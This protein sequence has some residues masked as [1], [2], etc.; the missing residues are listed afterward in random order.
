MQQR[1]AALAILVAIAWLVPGVARPADHAVLGSALVVKDPSTPEKR[2]AATKAKDTVPTGA[3][4][5]NPIADGA[6]L[7]VDL[8]GARPS[9]QTFGLPAGTSPLRGKPFWSGDATKGFKYGDP[10]GEN[11]PVKSAQIKSTKGLLQLKASI[12]GK[13]G[14]VSL[15][16]PNP[17]T[18]GCVL[19]T[20]N[21]GD[22]YSVRFA[23]G[24]RTNTA[25]AFKMVKPSQ[26]GSC[27]TDIS[28]TTSTVV[29][30][31]TDVAAS[32]TSTSAAVA[33]SSTS[34]TSTST[35]PPTT[36][37]GT[38]ST[39]STSLPAGPA[40]LELTLASH[41]V[42]PGATVAV[43]S[44]VRDAAGSLIAPPPAVTLSVEAL[45]TVNGPTPT[46]MD[47]LVVVDLDTTGNFLVRGQV[48]G[49]SIDATTTVSVLA[50]S[51]QNQQIASVSQ[52][53]VSIGVALAA[54]ADAIRRGDEASASSAKAD[55]QIAA[56]GIDHDLLAA[57]AVYAPAA[58][59]P[60][61]T[62]DLAAAG[63]SET[64][65]DL[66][67][68]STVSSLLTEYDGLVAFLAGLDGTNVSD[69]QIAALRNHVTTIHALS[70]TLAAATPTVVG[71]TEA[72]DDLTVLLMHRV[73]R[74][75]Q[76]VAQLAATS[77]G[78]V[79]VAATPA[80]SWIVEVGEALGLIARPARAQFLFDILG[81]LGAEGELVSATE[82]MYGD[83]IADIENAI[84]IVT[85]A[86]LIRP[87][88]GSGLCAAVGS[89]FL[90]GVVPDNPGSYLEGSGFDARLENNQTLFIG[91]EALSP[92]RNFVTAA[93]LDPEHIHNLFDVFLFFKD[94]IELLRAP[95]EA[96]EV[97][98]HATRQPSSI[99]PGAGFI[100]EIGGDH[101]VFDE[102]FPDVLGS[103]FICIAPII[104]I[105]HDV[106]HG[107]VSMLTVNMIRP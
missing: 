68:R 72:A 87:Y 76:L 7:R 73:P 79:G 4:V 12:T 65:A 92:V 35:T 95:G 62:A 60:P 19:L 41:V 66:T 44:A 94:L 83:A 15:V 82:L 31:S 22:S 105:H 57:A 71:V 61:T 93:T 98:E 63:Y 45:G 97:V 40:S 106:V 11:G 51:E 5:G 88:A 67:Y 46:I 59:F 69:A 100:C 34:S 33:S 52:V 28:T 64:P 49:F 30:S 24:T 2:S 42:T 91:P 1:L 70:S 103:C 21:G 54:A 81:A 74:V 18:V 89:A 6:T 50:S 75:A 39:T 25:T 85:I 90:S 55:I 9:S 102:G 56:A 8:H 26:A 20:L 13:L 17:G 36:T 80:E 53:G 43:A 48:V 27:V 37:T 10:L 16:P 32:T 78:A 77:L 107:G 58:G 47:G 104:V 96:P 23:D 3:I 101:L 38:S 29:T 84:L 14:T 99:E 86:D